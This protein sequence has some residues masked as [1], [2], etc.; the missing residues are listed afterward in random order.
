[1]ADGLTFTVGQIT[2][3]TG[4]GGFTVMTTEEAQIQSASTMTSPATAPTMLAAS[5]TTPATSPTTLATRRLLPR[6]KWRQI[7]NTDLLEA[8]DRLDSKLSES[9]TLVDSIQNQSTK[10]IPTH[11]NRSTRPARA[12]HPAWL[13][14][15]LVVTTT[16]DG[17]TVRLCPVPATGLRLS[18]HQ[19]LTE[20]RRAFPHGLANAAS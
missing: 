15:D 19:T 5:S 4:A 3:T 1:M 10:Q 14:T 6:Y 2:W 7:D 8:I 18:K 17:R 20:H 12:C 9:L 16:P 11:H 13:D